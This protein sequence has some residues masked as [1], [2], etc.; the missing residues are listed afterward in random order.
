MA[1]KTLP[2]FLL[3]ISTF[4]LGCGAPQKDLALPRSGVLFYGDSIFGKWD[5]AAAF[6]GQPYVNGGHFGQ[7]T[8]Q[9]LAALPDAL[10]GKNVCS[11]FDGSATIPSTLY[12]RPITPPATIVIL[13]GWN[14]M[15]QG[16]QVDARPDIA[17]MVGLSREA[18]VRVVLCTVYPY[19]IGHP[20]SWMVPTGTAPVTFYDMWRDPLN[21]AIR[22]IKGPDI[23]VVDL[24]S[25][26]GGESDYTAD[27][28]HPVAAGYAQMH[29]AIAPALN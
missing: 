22:S 18:G 15:F 7:R 29:D 4:I 24:S 14:N 10:S 27:G 5:L 21:D 13:A 2:L 6:P 8:D 9:L 12:C 11:G 23:Q 28:V 25:I 3:T 20:A 16:Y 19:D 1:S 17:K 26:F